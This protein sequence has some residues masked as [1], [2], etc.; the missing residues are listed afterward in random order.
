MK[1]D[2]KIC[3]ILYNTQGSAGSTSSLIND[4]SF[5][6]LAESRDE[7]QI[8]KKFLKEFG[9]S[10]RV[11]GIQR[12]NARTVSKI[13]EVNPDFVFNLCESLYE[14]SQTEMYV[15]GMLELLRI[16]YTGNPP[17]AL[18]LALNK[19]K[20]KQIF[21]S[22]GIPTPSS[23]VVPVG[24]MPNVENL[25]PPYIVKPVREDGSAGIT[26]DSVVETQGEVEK[27]I[28]IIHKEYNQPAVVE[29]FIEGRE[30]TVA[31]V[32]N[33][34]RVLGIGEI[35]FSNIPK[36]EPKIISYKTKWDAE[37]PL[38]TIFPADI[39]VSLKNRIEKYALKAFQAI[40]CRD[41][42]RIDVRVSENRRIYILEINTNPVVSPE[43]GFEDA[44]KS[45]GIQ[46][47]NFLR[48]LVENT[49]ARRKNGN[50][51]IIDTYESVGV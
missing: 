7:V 10:V 8:I 44:A 5:D 42:V 45:S 17:F 26:K 23:I 19:M 31:V 37:K 12:I 29:E 11:M 33:P 6:S 38:D 48:E 15:A 4:D 50:S 30:F 43:S 18:G 22:A 47:S 2:G 3:L 1:L 14:R 13:E 21:D 34:P 39:D 20:C 24:E 25:T 40:G 16:P 9:L 41:Y 28:V 35:N 27:L 49:L 51:D 32:G 36:K 46:Y